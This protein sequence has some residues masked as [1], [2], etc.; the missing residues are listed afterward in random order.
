MERF[1]RHPLVGACVAAA[2]ATGCS[3][4]SSDDN[5]G[6]V[7]GGSLGGRGTG[8]LG[9]GKGDL[10]GASA[11]KHVDL[12]ISVDGSSSMT[13]ELQAMRT[14]IFPA[15]AQRLGT[16]SDGLEDF[17]VG[18]VDACPTPSNLH[19]AGQGEACNFSSGQP[20]IESASPNID[21]EFACVGDILLSDQQCSGNNDDEQ[22]A[23]A[24]AA[25]LESSQNSAFQRSDALTV[26]VAITDED[27]QPTGAARTPEEVYTRLVDTVGGDPRRLVFLGIGGSRD[28]RGGVYGDAEEANRMKAITELFDAH[29]RG[30]FWDLCEGQLEDGLGEAFGVIESACN[31]LCALDAT[32]GGSTTEP[33]STLFCI[34]FPEDPSCLIE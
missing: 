14:T 25:A 4:T 10:V 31:D 16:I 15:F 34:E 9:D 7:T 5:G 3:S 6:S 13:E 12:I 20:W 11:C 1:T 2:L 24:A 23:S 29:G 8:G 27:E 30:V 33:P 26:I 17:R 21:A 32:C 22:P 28:C 18:T 19:T